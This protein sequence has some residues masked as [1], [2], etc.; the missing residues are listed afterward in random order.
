[1]EPWERIDNLQRP[2]I[3][4]GVYRGR[5]G[6]EPGQPTCSGPVRRRPGWSS[7]EPHHRPRARTHSWMTAIRAVPGRAR[8]R[9]TP[10]A[11]SLRA[12][13]LWQSPR[14]QQ[15][16]NLR[17]QLLREVL[18]PSGA[19]VRCAREVEIL[20]GPASRTEDHLAQARPLEG[21][22]SSHARIA[23]NRASRAGGFRRQ[24]DVEPR[25]H[26][27]VVR[28]PTALASRAGARPAECGSPRS[29]RSFRLR[30]ARLRCTMSPWAGT[31]SQVDRKVISRC[32]GFSS[33]ERAANH[34]GHRGPRASSRTPRMRRG[35]TRARV[36]A[37]ATR[38]PATH[39]PPS[40][41]LSAPARTLR[42]ASARPARGAGHLRYLPRRNQ[43]ERNCH[44][45]HMG[46]D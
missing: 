38:A 4:S 17:A 8:V 34:P 43:R 11:S 6:T 30:R 3:R 7:L 13:Q 26:D 29:T 22:L 20:R 37:V 18:A 14:P 2:G 16:S 23:G 39:R 42:V 9:A 36:T 15:L 32:A 40:P 25:A 46:S 5:I 27:A 41:S 31:R 33:S 44:G 12:D 21:E 35:R 19:S 1:M 10:A 24:A 28:S 45:T